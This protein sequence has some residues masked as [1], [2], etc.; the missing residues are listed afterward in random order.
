MLGKRLKRAIIGIC[1]GAGIA[2]GI[3][4]GLL[5]YKNA[6]RSPVNVY[7]MAD[8]AMQDPEG[9][10]GKVTQGSVTAEG[11]QKVYLSSSQNVADVKVHEGQEIKK[12]EV[13]FSYDTTLSDLDVDRANVKVGRME[14]ELKQATDELNKLYNMQ[15]HTTQTIQPDHK[16]EYKPVETPRKLAGSGT[17]ED[18]YIYMISEDDTISGDLLKKLLPTDEKTNDEKKEGDSKKEVYIALITRENNALNAQITSKQGV[19]LE[20]ENSS[21]SG[22]GI[23]NPF[24]PASIEAYEEQPEPYEVESGSEHTAEELAQLRASKEKEIADMKRNISLARNEYE[25]LKLETEDNSVKSTTD[26]VVTK[27]RS[28]GEARD[29]NNAFI[30]VSAGGG[31]F[32]TG[33][34]NEFDRDDLSV[35]QSVD[36]SVFAMDSGDSTDYKGEIIE[37][38]DRPVRSDENTDMYGGYSYGEGN[39]NTSYFPFKVKLEKDAGLNENT[40]AE[41]AYS[42]DGE[43]GSEIFLPKAFI[44]TESGD[45]YVYIKG[46]KDTLERKSVKTGRELWGEYIQIKNGI[47]A[48]DMIA[49]PYGKNVF[50]GAKTKVSDIEALYEDT[51]Y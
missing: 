32:V 39:T 19:R 10:G 4:A 44:R 12:G 14:L 34:V 49:F 21:I 23:F 38:S 25:R 43:N 11:I 2:G 8:L 27:V 50:E 42:A 22:M 30:E 16:V 33:T 48:E 5:I 51:G 37:I 41:I 47:E 15:P 6:G 1:V 46:D 13:L 29:G 9:T 17:M 24:L 7:A 18:P 35:G 31:Y 28:E 3:T 40:Y 26:G 45:S 20:V 36:V